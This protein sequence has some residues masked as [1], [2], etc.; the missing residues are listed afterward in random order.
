MPPPSE[1]G[2]QTMIR[3]G[4]LLI[5]AMA[6]LA[7]A[8]PGWGQRYWNW[9]VY[10][11]PAGMSESGCSAVTVGNGKVLVRHLNLPRFSTLDGYFVTNSPAPDRVR[12]RIYESPAGQL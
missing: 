10:R 3:N 8:Q 11:A 9:R 5:L 7:L 1:G 2:S 6:F 12:H 4:R